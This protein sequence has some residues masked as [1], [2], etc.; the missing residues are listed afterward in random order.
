MKNSK[1]YPEAWEFFI[2][3][4]RNIKNEPDIAHL[5][6]YR[7]SRPDESG[8]YIYANCPGKLFAI[9]KDIFYK[10]S[11]DSPSVYGKIQYIVRNF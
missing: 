8:K 6:D 5:G 4:A 3:H 7:I 10:I 2:E 1:A 11:L 9:F